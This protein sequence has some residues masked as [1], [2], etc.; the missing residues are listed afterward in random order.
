MRVEEGKSSCD[1]RG[2]GQRG[3]VSVWIKVGTGPWRG[4]GTRLLYA[5]ALV[6]LDTGLS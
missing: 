6:R 2:D 1:Q 4:T 3:E 5:V